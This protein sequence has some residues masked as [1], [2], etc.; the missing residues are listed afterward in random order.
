MPAHA[1]CP[2]A[3]LRRGLAGTAALPGALAA[4]LALTGACAPLPDVGAPAVPATAQQATAA[5]R[6]VP[7]GPALAAAEAGTLTEASADTL[8][9]RA[10]ALR[11]RGAALRRAPTDG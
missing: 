4:A 11:A 10:A 7:L 2:P 9:A 1:T 3:R 8:A 6:L 5:P